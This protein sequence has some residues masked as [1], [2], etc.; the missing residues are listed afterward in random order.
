MHD[1][2]VA[3]AVGFGVG[4]E[5][6]ADGPILAEMGLDEGFDF[7]G[8][9]AELCEMYFSRCGASDGVEYLVCDLDEVA[10][11]VCFGFPGR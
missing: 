5:F 2:V 11:G 8:V 9:K 3:S 6:D 7:V 4:G 10:S 1:I